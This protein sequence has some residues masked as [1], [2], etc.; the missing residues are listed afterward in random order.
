MNP[1]QILGVSPEDDMK[2][3]RKKYV[4]LMLK[5]HPD[6]VGDKYLD[7]CK[8]VMGAWRKIVGDEFDEDEF[9]ISQA[10]KDLGFNRIPSLHEYIGRIFE[11]MVDQNLISKNNI[12]NTTHN[13]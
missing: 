5:L 9:A 2:V 4:S 11:R 6:K 3:I 13:S 12:A 8:K 7:E 1:Y 10:F